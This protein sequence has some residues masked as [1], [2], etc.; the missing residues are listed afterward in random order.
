MALMT[1]KRVRHLPVLGDDDSV[2]GVISIGDVGKA[3][4]A[5]QEFTIA[6]LEHY[7]TGSEAMIYRSS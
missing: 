2:I 5:H 7:I 4:I 6:Q 3:I 1:E